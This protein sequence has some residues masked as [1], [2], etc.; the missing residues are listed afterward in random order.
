MPIFLVSVSQL[1]VLHGRFIPRLV[2]N[3]IERII[4]RDMNMSL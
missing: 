2:I 3:S 4:A 1:A